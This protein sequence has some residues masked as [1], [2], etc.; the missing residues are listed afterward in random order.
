MTASEYLVSGKLDIFIF[1]ACLDVGIERGIEA[2]VLT[3][4]FSRRP[5]SPVERA[6]VT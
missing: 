6:A 3:R 2:Q 1:L 5:L 4:S